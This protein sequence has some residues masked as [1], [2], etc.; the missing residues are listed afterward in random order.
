MRFPVLLMLLAATLTA[1]GGSSDSTGPSDTYSGTYTLRTVNGQSLPFLHD[2]VETTTIEV[3]SDTLV[4]ADDG[5]GGS[6]TKQMEIRVTAS[7]V[8]RSQPLYDAGVYT[9]NGTAATFRFNPPSSGCLYCS[10]SD[11][12][13]AVGTISGGTITFSDGAGLSYVYKK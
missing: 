12:P 5:N 3:V 7:G 2:Q 13:T 8:A 11:G 10:D 1:C 9:R 4:I 6:F